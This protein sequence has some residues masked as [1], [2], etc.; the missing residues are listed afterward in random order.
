VNRDGIKREIRPLNEDGD[1][2]VEVAGT[3]M[4]ED[5][6]LMNGAGAAGSAELFFN[7]AGFCQRVAGSA[8]LFFNSAAF[9]QIRVRS[10]DGRR[11]RSMGSQGCR[12]ASSSSDPEYSLTLDQGQSS[13]FTARPRRTGFRWMYSTALL[14]SLTVLNARSKKRPCQSFPASLRLL[15]IWRVEL[16]LMDSMTT[17]IVFGYRT[18]PRSRHASGPAGKLRPLTGSYAQSAAQ[19]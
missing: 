1:A 9:C 8:E 7:S 19:I 15:L 17:E 5:Y 3:G 12:V 11:T 10:S 18:A 14:Y 16:T 6:L 2:T 13:G 4:A